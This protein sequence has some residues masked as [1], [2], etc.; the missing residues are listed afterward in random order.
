MFN[1]RLTLYIFS[2]FF[3]YYITL[4]IVIYGNLKDPKFSDKKQ[5]SLD[6]SILTILSFT[7]WHMYQPL[8][9]NFSIKRYLLTLILPTVSCLTT[10][11]L[12]ETSPFSTN[13]S[14]INIWDSFNWLVFS[15]LI[16]LFLIY[17]I[18]SWRLRYS[19]Y[20]MM[21]DISMTNLS[22][23]EETTNAPTYT[24]SLFIYKKIFIP[25]IIRFLLTILWLV[26][27]YVSSGQFESFYLHHLLLFSMLAVI[28]NRPR[29]LHLI[30]IG[31]A[32]HG[33][34]AYDFPIN[35]FN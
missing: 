18:Y 8:S 15:I 3:A 35:L 21:T 26:V 11:G 19:R 34:V 6:L 22:S 5:I 7:F 27:I 23:V 29:T 16:I 4:P 17:I 32:I 12:M 2:F 25:I 28:F 33:L 24:N 9:D 20:R 13:F 14:S 1:L 30:F 10:L 31:V